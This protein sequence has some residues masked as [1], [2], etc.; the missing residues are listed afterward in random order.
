MIRL[1][2]TLILTLTA[3]CTYSQDVIYSAYDK[4]DHLNGEYAVVGMTGGLLYT[5]R[6]SVDGA[7]LEAFDDSMNKVTIVNLD[8]FPIKIYDTK[9]IAYPDKII[10]LYQGLESNKVVQYAAVLNQKGLLVGKPIQLYTKKTGIF[11]A[12]KN[13]F[14]SAVS[15]DKKKILIYSVNNKGN[16]LELDCKWLNDSLQLVS[17][18]KATFEANKSI[19]FGELNISN[20]GTIYMAAYTE[21]GMQN[22]ADQFWVLTLAQGETKITAHEMQLGDRYAASGYMRLDNANGLAY[23]GGYYTVKKNGSYD[24]IIFAALDMNNGNWQQLKFLPYDNTLGDANQRRHMQHAYDNYQVRQVIAKNDGGFVMIAEV[25]Y[26]TTRTSYV[27]G[28]GYYSSFYS[29]YSS[30]MI[31]EYHFNDIMAFSYDKEGNRQWESVI[32]KEQYSQ[33]DGG[34]FSSYVM[35]NS[36]GSLAFLYNNFNSRHSSIQLATLSSEGKLERNSFTASGNDSPDWLPRS[37]KQVAS[38]ILIVPC[39]HKKQICFAK[40]VF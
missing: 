30:A 4:Y 36:G 24:G 28:L 16:D 35:L 21:V 14:Y 5:Y 15:D 40:V 17:K 34:M 8:F 26:I 6:N 2:A 37:G 29:P 27:P 31:H 13:Y 25:Q 39:L 1:L 12:M 33:Q 10:V 11:G 7:K 18:S 3:T 38:R 23:F 32:P 20:S 9:F 19:S 22:Y